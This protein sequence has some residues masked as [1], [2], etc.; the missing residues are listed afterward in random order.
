MII[1]VRLR[2]GAA[3]PDL[4]GVAEDISPVAQ[5]LPPDTA[6]IDVAGARRYFGQDAAGIASVLRV[7]ALAHAGADCAIGVAA[8]PLPARM[9]ARQAA[10]G[11]TLVVADDPRELA[12]FLAP[13]PVTALPGVGAATARTL[14]TYG[15]DTVGKAAGVPLATLQRLLGVRV[16]R[17][18]HEKALGID[19]TRVVPDEGARTLAAERAF[20]HDEVDRDAQRRALL[21]AAGELGGRLRDSHQVCRSL[22]LVVR[23][24]DGSTTQ[25]TRTL[26]EATAHSPALTATAY[27]MHD[28]LGLQR[29]RVRAFSLRADGL[30]P[31]ARA[32]RQLTLD[33]ADERARRLEETADRARARFGP[34]AIRPG[35]LAA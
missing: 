33:P 15:L 11:T 35:T 31:E 12:A 26:P 2:D 4:L 18:V 17:E 13:K 14:R 29:A 22:T 5:A 3:L 27:R 25:R 10:Y 8:T 23:Y 6:L 1:C 19:R 9:A 30:A 21:S 16:G 32:T 24:A 28:A 20:G 7:R 34:S